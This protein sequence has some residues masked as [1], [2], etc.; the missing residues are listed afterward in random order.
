M[1][2]VREALGLRRDGNLKFASLEL[3]PPSLDH[4]SF[5]SLLYPPGFELINYQT[6]PSSYGKK[7]RDKTCSCW[8]QER[9][10]TK[11]QFL[12]DCS[13]VDCFFWS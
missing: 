5:T 4:S 6:S 7:G 12:I 9:K 8:R 2:E 11:E 13:I 1:I 10:E 3:S